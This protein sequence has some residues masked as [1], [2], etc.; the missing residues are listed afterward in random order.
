MSW[1]PDRINLTCHSDSHHR[2]MPVC[3]STVPVVAATLIILFLE[4]KCHVSD[5][6]SLNPQ[7]NW[8]GTRN[9]MPIWN[10][11]CW[12]GHHTMVFC[13]STVGASTVINSFSEE[14]VPRVRCQFTGTATKMMWQKEQNCNS[15]CGAL[16]LSWYYGTLVAGHTSVCTTTWISKTYQGI[17]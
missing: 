2:L 3:R 11:K 15:A 16:N 5:T 6:D 12:T 1:P 13:I 10:M 9:K 8:C 14:N 4:R 17:N 7:Q